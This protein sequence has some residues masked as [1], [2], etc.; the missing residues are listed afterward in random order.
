MAPPKKRTHIA[1]SFFI[2]IK[3]L[4]CNHTKCV[5][6]EADFVYEVIFEELNASLHVL[7]S[8][9]LH[10]SLLLLNVKDTSF[11]PTPHAG[12]FYYTALSLYNSPSY[13]IIILY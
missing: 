13:S 6:N 10:S 2:Q 7:H 3:D 1:F 9:I 11:L 12:V 5:C 4:E 8:K